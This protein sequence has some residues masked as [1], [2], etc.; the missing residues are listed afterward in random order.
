VAAAD[1]DIVGSGLGPS[2]RK[3]WLV[4][5]LILTLGPLALV[6]VLAP[7]AQSSPSTALVW[8]LFVGS[9]VHVGATA[10][11]YTISEVRAHMRHHRWRYY[12]IP[13]ALIVAVDTISANGIQ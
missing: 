11:F 4:A 3:G 2:L 10:W 8:L 5:T 9:S 7:P 1:P 6:V 13:L 12:W